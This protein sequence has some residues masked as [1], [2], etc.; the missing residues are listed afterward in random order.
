MEEL[1]TMT[2]SNRDRRTF[3]KGA[4]VGLALP[5]QESARA[6]EST[7]LQSRS[8]AQRFVAI[9]TYLGFHTPSRF[10]HANHATRL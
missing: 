8:P 6:D 3:L 7:G 2:E 4:G 9:G 1:I 5:M 10:A